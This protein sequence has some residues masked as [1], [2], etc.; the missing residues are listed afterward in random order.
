MSGPRTRKV[1]QY[2]TSPITGLNLR[3]QFSHPLNVWR[4]I[5]LLALGG[6]FIDSLLVGFRLHELPG[7]TPRFHLWHLWYGPPLLAAGW[8]LIRRYRP[9][10][11]RWAITLPVFDT[12]A[13]SLSPAVKSLA[14]HVARSETQAALLTFLQRQPTLSLTASDLAGTVE[15]DLDDVELA[16]RQLE[17]LDLVERQQVC[18]LTFYRLTEDEARRQQLREVAAW[19]DSWYQ[20]AQCLMQVVGRSRSASTMSDGS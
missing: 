6:W 15:R 12:V 5:A 3:L 9:E 11:M 19:Q 2:P 1:W 14:F 7:A 13:R 8:L 10:L 16:L 17:T 18:D 4:M 20:Q